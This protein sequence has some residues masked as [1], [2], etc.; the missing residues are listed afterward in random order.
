MSSAPAVWPVRTDTASLRRRAVIASVL[1]WLGALAAL[2]LPVA[3]LIVAVKRVPTDPLADAL[4]PAGLVG[5]PVTW[6]AAALGAAAWA[7]RARVD[8]A[9]VTAERHRFGAPWAAMGWFVPIAGLVIPL[10]VVTDLVRAVRPAGVGTATVRWWWGAWIAG[11]VVLPACGAA[12]GMIRHPDLVLVPSV[13]LATLLLVV[14]AALFTRIVLAVTAAQNAALR[15]F[16]AQW[17]PPA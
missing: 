1:V 9:A 6:F 5:V 15:G 7:W 8:A 16:A 10:L 12:S 3:S 2:P 14:A 4:L 11:S 17:A 13:T